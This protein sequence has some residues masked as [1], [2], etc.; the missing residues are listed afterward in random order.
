[1][2]SAWDHVSAPTQ[3]VN[4]IATSYIN[5]VKLYLIQMRVTR[6]LSLGDNNILLIHQCAKHPQ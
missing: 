3:L 1:M 5:T 2:V 6:F 4:V